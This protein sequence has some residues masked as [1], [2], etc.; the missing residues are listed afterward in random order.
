MTDNRSYYRAISLAQ[1]IIED[2]HIT[3]PAQIVIEDIAAERKV[4]VNEDSIRGSVARLVRRGNT[5]LITVDKDIRE[6]G[7]KR[8]AVAHEFGH[9][10]LHKSQNQLE[11][12]V[13][14]MFLEWYKS[15]P[16]EPEANAF[17]A[18]LLM[19]TNMFKER[20]TADSPSFHEIRSLA[21]QFQTTITA[22][23]T[24][25][26]ELGPYPCALIVS[27]NGMVRWFRSR[28]DFPYR[29]ISRGE[30][31]S[32][33]SCA[34]DFFTKGSVPDEPEVV[35]GQ[36]WL[37]DWKSGE[38]IPLYEHAFALPYYKTVLSLLWVC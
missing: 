17:A 21:D 14:K 36:A 5:A 30:K 12:C 26:V 19:P 35:G 13:D 23:A 20:C 38:S 31:I 16:E 9:F 8:F 4:Y 11:N 7:K 3:D 32:K 6:F 29:I 18:E 24:R 2:L 25:Y 10:E 34:H 28:P 1:G 37:E 15:R 22:T 33:F 27:E